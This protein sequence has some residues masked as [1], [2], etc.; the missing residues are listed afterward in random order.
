VRII[1]HIG[2]E[3]TGTSSIQ[4]FCQDNRDALLRQGVYYPKSPSDSRGNHVKL[5]AYF[6]ENDWIGFLL[7]DMGIHTP[8]QLRDFRREFHSQLTLELRR[9]PGKTVLFSNEHTSMTYDEEEIGRL[10]A[11]LREFTNDIRIVVYLRRQMDRYVALH[12]TRVVRG[13]PGLNLNLPPN[14][15]H[16][17]GLDYPAQMDRWARIFGRRNIIVRPFERAQLAGGDVVRD[18]LDVLGLKGDFVFSRERN[19][20]ASRECI[21]FLTHMYEF[22]PRMQGD[23]PHPYHRGIGE[24]VKSVTSGEPFTCRNLQLLE[25]NFDPGN[26]EVARKYLG[27]EDGVLFRNPPRVDAREAP[28]LTVEQA[29][30]IAAR[31]WVK[32]CG[33][34]DKMNDELAMCRRLAAQLGAEGVAL[35]KFIERTQAG[36][37]HRPGERLPEEPKRASV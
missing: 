27:R 34:I 1:L 20:R 37:T 18:F 9:V 36:H 23:Q 2:F 33:V 24:A 35:P 17:T 30:E 14:C 6:Q 28:P 5:A 22:L 16:W 3:K 13:E 4:Q 15:T 19:K 7:K 29:V 32:Q 21:Q 26:A 8:E 31:L 11:L 10:A 25:S 12:A